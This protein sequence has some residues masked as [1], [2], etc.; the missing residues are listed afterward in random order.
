MAPIAMSGHTRSN[1]LARLLGLRSYP[2]TVHLRLGCLMV[3]EE[4]MLRE[5][6]C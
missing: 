4:T 3:R 6:E 1:L 2:A 5:E